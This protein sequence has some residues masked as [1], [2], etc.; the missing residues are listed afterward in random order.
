ML[1][2]HQNLGYRIVFHDPFV[3]RRG[4]ALQEAV[5]DSEDGNVLN[6]W[7]VLWV[8]RDQVM[9]IVVELPPTGAQAAHVRCNEH[10][11]SR[12]RREVVCNA[13]VASIMDGEGELMPDA[14]EWN[15]A[16]DIPTRV[17]SVEEERDERPVS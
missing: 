16:R 2:A 5:G 13:H 7:I 15:R 6:V 10:C 8:V 4:E 11:D 17:Q 14:G 12:V 9:D 3:I 1:N